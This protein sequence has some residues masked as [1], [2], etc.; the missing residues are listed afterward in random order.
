M[1]DNPGGDCS[2]RFCPFE[3]AWV[4]SPLLDGSTHNYAECA[5]KGKCNR[6]TGEC[7]CYSGYEGK[8]CGRQ[9]CPNS[10]SGHGTCEAMK[11]LTYG[12]VYNDYF[13]GSSLA[14]SGLGSGGKTFTDHS[15]DTERAR[16]CVCDG[17]WTGL[18]CDLRFCPIGNDIMDVIPLA[19][20]G[21]VPQVQTITLYD[22][23]L[24]NANFAGK[25][26]AIQFTTKLNETFVTQPISWN[27]VGTVLEGYIESALKKL[28][29]K[30]MDDVTVSIDLSNGTNGVIINVTFSGNTVQGPQHK[31]EIL[32]DE[33]S[34]GCTPRITGLTNL[35][36]FSSGTL[37]TVKVSTV[38]SHTSYECGNRGKCVRS[39]GVCA[40]FAGFAGDNCNIFNAVS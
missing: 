28:P 19:H 14:L 40:C 36:T 1:G 18:S 27:V 13:D 16:T 9:S 21:E 10:C 20:G 11:D 26:F 33:C 35:V 12:N 22:A 3:L 24:N 4:D 23:A 25:D 39:I 30:V 34:D 17:G 29:N 38:G 37:S 6:V 7:E 2:E 5:N 31:L 8:A 32:T 15:W